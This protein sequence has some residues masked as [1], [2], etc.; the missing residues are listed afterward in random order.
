MPPRKIGCL[1]RPPQTLLAAG[2][3]LL[4]RVAKGGR[5]PA[6]SHTERLFISPAPD[7][8][9]RSIP[10]RGWQS[11]HPLSW[12]WA[13]VWGAVL[14]GVLDHCRCVAIVDVATLRSCSPTT[15]VIVVVVIV[16]IA[17]LNPFWSARQASCAHGARR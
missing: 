11:S 7:P 17:L 14:G 9:P 12:V 3:M 16:A 8:Q 6:V 15:V 4:R 2:S 13:W 1:F 5:W 10:A